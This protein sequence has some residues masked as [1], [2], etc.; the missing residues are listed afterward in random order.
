VAKRFAGLGIAKI[1]EHLAPGNTNL[2]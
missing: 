2:Q 1:V